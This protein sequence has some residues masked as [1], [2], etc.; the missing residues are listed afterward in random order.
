MAISPHQFLW[1]A[2]IAEY[3]E[4]VKFNT[5]FS[6]FKREKL[7]NP[8]M[9]VWEQCIVWWCRKYNKNHKSHIFWQ[10]M[11]ENDAWSDV[12][13]FHTRKHN[14][15]VLCSACPCVLFP[16]PVPACYAAALI[17]RFFQAYFPSVH[18]WTLKT[19][20]DMEGWHDMLVS[21]ISQWDLP[22]MLWPK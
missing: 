4:C 22:L 12:H 5:E 6:S 20:S 1:Y 10:V 18:I 15:I 21:L 2:H 11:S 9:C 7:R 8:L 14:K 17:V 13:N 19:A 16:L 3:T